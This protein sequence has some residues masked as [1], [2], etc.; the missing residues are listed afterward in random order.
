MSGDG[1][2]LDDVQNMRI[3]RADQIEAGAQRTIEGGLH[4]VVG[5]GTSGNGF[6]LKQGHVVGAFTVD[7]SN[8]IKYVNVT[9]PSSSARLFYVL[10]LT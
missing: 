10:V 7:M 1:F 2:N 9:P 8:P 4:T 5:A 3:E 6:T